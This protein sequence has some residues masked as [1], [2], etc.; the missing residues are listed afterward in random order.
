[1]KWTDINDIAIELS[2]AHPDKD[3][4]KINFVDLRDTVMAL[5]PAASA[6]SL[7]VTRPLARERRCPPVSAGLSLLA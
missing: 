7:K 3:P 4:L 6:T 2:E 5:T 1:M